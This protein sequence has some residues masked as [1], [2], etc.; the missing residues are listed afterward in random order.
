MNNLY[1][2]TA[3]KGQGTEWT[4]KFHKTKAQSKLNIF[5]FLFQIMFARLFPSI[6]KDFRNFVVLILLYILNSITHNISKS[7]FFISN[8]KM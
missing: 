7:N 3:H 2:L 1:S 8:S 5:I 6:C 4:T